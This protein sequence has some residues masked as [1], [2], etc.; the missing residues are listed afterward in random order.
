MQREA[1]WPGQLE[2]TTEEYWETGPADGRVCSERTELPWEALGSDCCREKGTE[3]PVED[4]EA[5]G[6]ER[7]RKN[8][9]PKAGSAMGSESTHFQ[10][11]LQGILLGI[12]NIILKLEQ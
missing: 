8:K 12:S 10:K 9:S 2:K 4:G 6:R 1:V 11:A 5:L 3:K 7:G